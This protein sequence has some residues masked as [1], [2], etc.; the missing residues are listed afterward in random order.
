LNVLALPWVALVLAGV[1]FLVTVTYPDPTRLRRLPRWVTT[2][3]LLRL[4][5]D[6]VVSAVLMRQEPIFEP[7]G[8]VSAL[9]WIPISGVVLL[10]LL[11][12]MLGRYQS[13]SV[14][15]THTSF[16]QVAL[17]AQ[18]MTIDADL[19]F[20][21]ITAQEAFKQC[22][23]LAELQA[24]FDSL[25]RSV[26]FA[27]VDVWISCLLRLVTG[28][29]AWLL[30]DHGQQSALELILVHNLLT[31]VTCL[32][33]HEALAI[34]DWRAANSTGLCSEPWLIAPKGRTLGPLWILVLALL[35]LVVLLLPLRPFFLLLVIVGLNL[36]LPAHFFRWHPEAFSAYGPAKPQAWS[37]LHGVRPPE[38]EH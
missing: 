29:Q 20:G 4:L 21:H 31:T 26:F 33:L 2:I 11:M 1:I 37:E 27:R 15:S 23:D 19:H 10:Q 22:R 14:S 34:T 38:T 8:K 13:A 5:A 12:V 35:L 32:W 30:F 28:W 18:R 7:S 25:R 6:L 3:I 36:L 17:S 24:F 16:T 9:V